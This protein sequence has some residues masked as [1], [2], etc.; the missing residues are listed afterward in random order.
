MFDAK[1]SR[2]PEGYGMLIVWGTV[3]IKIENNT[4]MLDSRIMAYTCNNIYTTFMSE[5][6]EFSPPTFEDLHITYNKAKN[7]SFYF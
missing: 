6:S 4:F 5:L 1:R 3:A 7:G 2:K